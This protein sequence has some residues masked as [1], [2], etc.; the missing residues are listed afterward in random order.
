MAA[1]PLARIARLLAA[2]G[3]IR[4]SKSGIPRRVEFSETDLPKNSSGKV[5]KKTLRER[6]W[7]REQRAVS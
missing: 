6:F 5:L 7:T 1:T 4:I 3:N 2:Q